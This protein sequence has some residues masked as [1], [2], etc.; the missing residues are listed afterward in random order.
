HGPQLRQVARE[1]RADVPAEPELAGVVVLDLERGLGE[2]A[3][4]YGILPRRLGCGLRAHEVEP[5]VARVKEELAPHPGLREP[6]LL[7]PGHRP[8]LEVEGS[9]CQRLRDAMQGE[10]VGG[11]GEDELPGPAGR[12]FVDRRLDR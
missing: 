8:E 9:A 12:L 10:Q 6:E 11:A 2:A 1:E 7:A 4:G 3:P 5:G